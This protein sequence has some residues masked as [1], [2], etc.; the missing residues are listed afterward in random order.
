[1]ILSEKLTGLADEVRDVSSLSQ[2]LSIEDITREASQI[3]QTL[4]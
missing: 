2:R 4:S 3:V 1:M